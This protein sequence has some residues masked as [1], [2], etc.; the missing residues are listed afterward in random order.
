MK[1]VNRI[2]YA[3]AIVAIV[4]VPFLPEYQS[5]FLSFI[6]ACLGWLYP[7]VWKHKRFDEQKEKEQYEVLKLK[8]NT[9][10]GLTTIRGISDLSYDQFWTHVYVSKEELKKSY[11]DRIEDNELEW[12]KAS[13]E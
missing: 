5:Y 9:V 4:L 1:T 2:V 6:T 12:E 3:L 10:N 7:C 13:Y 8:I 11:P